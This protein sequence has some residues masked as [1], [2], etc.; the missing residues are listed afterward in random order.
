MSHCAQRL[1]YLEH[2]QEDRARKRGLVLRLLDED[3]AIH[4][5]APDAAVR[6]G[7]SCCRPHLGKLLHRRAAGFELVMPAP[8]EGVARQGL[9]H[10]LE[11]MVLGEGALLLVLDFNVQ[12]RIPV[13]RA[14]L[15]GRAFLHRAVD[16]RARHLPCRPEPGQ[17][18]PVLAQGC[19]SLLERVDLEL[20]LILILF[21]AVGKVG[22]GG[23]AEGLLEHLVDDLAHAVVR[24]DEAA[25]TRSALGLGGRH[26]AARCSGPPNGPSMDRESTG[27]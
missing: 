19:R 12:R 18:Q 7:R 22:H 5:L 17:L 9:R 2:C 3:A 20:V 27:A 11:V 26:A 8:E 25:G 1:R 10:G 4:A 14:G 21:P 15:A 16:L 23:H 24:H 13:S 6:G